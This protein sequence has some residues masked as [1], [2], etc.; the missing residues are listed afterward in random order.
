MFPKA[1]LGII[2][3]PYGEGVRD[4]DEGVRMR[5]QIQVRVRVQVQFLE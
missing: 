3:P 1:A 2:A 4:E 5:V